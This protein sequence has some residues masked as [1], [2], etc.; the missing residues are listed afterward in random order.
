MSE[1]ELKN[2]IRLIAKTKRIS[3]DKIKSRTIEISS[4]VQPWQNLNY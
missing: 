2:G 4:T 1:I 3:K